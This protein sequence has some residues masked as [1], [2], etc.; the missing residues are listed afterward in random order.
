[1]KFVA[2][3]Y[4]H[5]LRNSPACIQL[6]KNAV[7]FYAFHHQFQRE[8]HRRI[9][10]ENTVHRDCHLTINSTISFTESVQYHSS[11]FLRIVAN[12]NK[13]RVAVATPRPLGFRFAPGA[14]STIIICLG[15]SLIAGV[16]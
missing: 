1:M 5:A 7:S 4:C 14:C 15:R 2:F 8:V 9:S 6:V 16:Y 11:G 3:G 10:L 12:A 13:R